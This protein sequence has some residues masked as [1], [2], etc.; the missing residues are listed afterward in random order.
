M[1]TP[2]YFNMVEEILK[3]VLRNVDIL[4]VCV[5]QTENT[6]TVLLSQTTAIYFSFCLHFK[7]GIQRNS[8]A[9]F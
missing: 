2:K 7:D 1:T 6:Y 5:S 8:F 9:V 4:C 3:S